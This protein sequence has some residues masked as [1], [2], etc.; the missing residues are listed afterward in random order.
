[1][2]RSSLEYLKHILEETNYLIE[3]SSSI[4][5]EAFLADKNLTRAFVRS[6][7]I[8]GE[9]TKSIDPALRKKYPEVDWRGMA[10]MRDILIHR[11]FGVDFEVVWDAIQTHIP[12]VEIAIVNILE[13]EGGTV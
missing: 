3:E 6:L 2:S 11:Y 10:G 9:A 7:E 1:M 12:Q 4:S 8:I 5:F 13:I